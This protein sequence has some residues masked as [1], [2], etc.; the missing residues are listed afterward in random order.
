MEWLHAQARLVLL[1]A[2]SFFRACDVDAL[3]T[4]ASFVV[5][6]RCMVC[7]GFLYFQLSTYTLLQWVRQHVPR[8]EPTYTAT[9]VPMAVGWDSLD[10]HAIAST[11]VLRDDVSSMPQ[12]GLH[13]DLNAAQ[14]RTPVLASAVED[15]VHEP[16]ETLHQ[17]EQAPFEPEQVGR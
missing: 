2:P 7:A 12:A 3:A 16:Q 1:H 9:N 15:H 4:S 8:E 10:S 13:E 6:R 14:A 11:A 5:R 17:A